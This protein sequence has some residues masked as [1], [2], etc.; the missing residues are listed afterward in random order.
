MEHISLHAHILHLSPRKVQAQFRSYYSIG[1]AF[2]TS[3]NH[4][5]NQFANIDFKLKGLH[6]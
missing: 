2:V 1:L 3:Q 6:I 5:F 4:H